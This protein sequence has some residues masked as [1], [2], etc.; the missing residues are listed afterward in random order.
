MKVLAVNPLKNPS[1]KVVRVAR[2][3]DERGYF[4]EIFRRSQIQELADSIGLPAGWQF[5]QINE[6]FS[7]PGV[8]RGLHTQWEPALGKLIRV[9][10][11]HMVDLFMD[12]RQSSPFFGQVIA[13]DMP[14][15][16]SAEYFE[17]IWI[18]A[19]FA[20]GNYFLADTT[21]EY[22]C[23]AEYNPNKEIGVNPLANDLDWSACDPT[24]AQ[25]FLEL[26]PKA[27]QSAKDA[28]G[29]TLANWRQHESAAHPLFK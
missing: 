21:I 26:K 13:Y 17:F 7:K 11:G 27:I 8:V 9:V 12:L 25:Q 2:F 28:Q 10:Q 16:P 18:P 19:G 4:T 15:Q 1:V 23:T 5:I 24:L 14:T 3:N 6:S 20:H 29:L 22:L